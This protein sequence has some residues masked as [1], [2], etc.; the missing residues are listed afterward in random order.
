MTTPDSEDFTFVDDNNT[1][2][3]QTAEDFKIAEAVALSDLTLAEAGEKDITITVGQG[4]DGKPLRRKCKAKAKPTVKKYYVIHNA[5]NHLEC[6]GIYYATWN[7][8]AR[9]I[10]PNQ[11]LCGS[12]CSLKGFDTFEEARKKWVESGWT[13]DP[14]FL[15]IA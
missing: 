13:S 2:E 6:L 9:D 1:E 11:K 8:V 15:E 10:L 4:R 12:G 3:K 5:P 14:P 7:D